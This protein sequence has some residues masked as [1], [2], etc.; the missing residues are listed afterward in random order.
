MANKHAGRRHAIHRLTP[1]YFPDERW[2]PEHS[3]AAT[4]RQINDGA[5]DGFAPSYA[6]TLARRGVD[7]GD[8]AW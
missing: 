3:A 1:T 4:D 8:R 7:D 5:M 6:K 2:D